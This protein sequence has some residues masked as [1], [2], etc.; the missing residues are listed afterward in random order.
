MKKVLAL[1]LVL[2]MVLGSFGLAFA[3]TPAQTT[4]GQTLQQ[5]GVLKGDAQGNLMLD[6]QLKR[7]DIIVLL[8]RLV[9]AEEEAAKFPIPTA[10]TDVTDAYY[11][12]FIGWAQV[13]GLTNGIGENKFG[14][15][16]ELTVKELSTMLLR[17]LGHGS[18]HAWDNAETLAVQLGLVATGTNFAAVASRAVMAE[19]TVGALKAPI[20]T[21]AK[22]SLGTKL[23]FAGYEIVPAKFEV[24]SLKATGAKKL[25]VQFNKEAAVTTATV[26]KGTVAVNTDKVEFAADKMSAVIT[27]TTN[28]TKGDYTVTV[29]GAKA[30]V[31]VEDVKVAKINILSAKAP[32]LAGDDTK[33]L[34]RYEVLNQYGEKMTGQSISWTISTGVAAGNINTI[35]G[36]F[37]ITAASGN[38]VPGAIVYITGVHATSGTVVNSQ[39]EIAL[40]SQ[41]DSVV[42]K[43]V[44]DTTKSELVSLPAGFANGRYVLLFEVKD[45]YGNKMGTPDLSKL[46][47]TSSNPLFVSSDSSAGAFD[48]ATDV[49]INDVTYTAVDL[50]AGSTVNDGGTVT[51][52]AI[53]TVTGKTSTITLNADAK[54]AVKTFTMSAPAKIVAETEEVEIPFTA[55]D[56]YGNAVTKYSALN[57]KVTLT[58]S[59]ASGTG[60]QF[61]EQNDGSAKLMYTAPA[62]GANDDFDLPVYLTSVV[63]VGGSFSSQMISVKETAR[64][65]AIVGVD[66]KKVTSIAAGNNVEILGTDL[67]IQDQYG[68]TMTKAQKETWLGTA[69]NANRIVLTSVFAASNDKSPFTVYVN[70]GTTDAEDQ[71]IDTKTDKFVIT[72]KTAANLNATEK[73]VFSL[74][75]NNGTNV[76]ST[77]AKSFTFT[78]VEQSAYVSFE[79]EALGT[80]YVNGT[81]TTTDSKYDKT[82]KVYGVLA[83][84]TKVQLPTSDY[85]VTAGTKLAVGTTGSALNV[86]SDN[87][88]LVA[89]DF[90]DTTGNYKDVKVNVLVTVNDNATGAALSIVEQELV[91]S[92]KAPKI[93]TITFNTTGDYTVTDGK[94]SIKHATGTITAANMKSFIKE[95]VDQ[96]G[97]KLTVDPTITITNLV[98]VDGSTFA[99]SANGSKTTGITGAKQGDKFRVTF[100]QDNATVTVDFTVGLNQ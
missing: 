7:Q 29:D 91:I 55:V 65:V 28:L 47:F 35:D 99:V 82:P 27:T 66:A 80:M 86:I 58:P 39:V 96:Y 17:A 83:N 43:G 34:V 25:T 14:F 60:L 97:V 95:V 20:A 54:A 56:Q 90:Q 12:P 77:S 9:G 57:G 24:V 75:T 100:K 88:V 2:S 79:V 13:E 6:S 19:A 30:T 72:A 45:Q 68:R 64:P 92:N 32:R 10:F 21:D 53:S 33:A 15:D 5:L 23:G 8:S 78:K 16:Q 36:T 81:V 50:V 89:G 74:A 69:S 38:F 1:V 94:A 52:Q 44:Y 37:E 67:V 87:N 93:A 18:A 51:I 70:A 49:E 98:K 11:K 85:T 26:A 41:A 3:A 40:A 73:L 61:V 59:F 22:K 76:L 31:T 48:A 42:F 46:V 62:T 4:A 84:G 63:T 71:M